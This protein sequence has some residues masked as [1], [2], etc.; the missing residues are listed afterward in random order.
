MPDRRSPA[1]LG[2]FMDNQ[3]HTVT[4][5]RALTCRILAPGLAAMA[6][7]CGSDPVNPAVNTPTAGDTSFSVNFLRAA[8][9]APPIANPI[10]SFYARSG[11]D[12]EAFMY[13]RPRPGGGGSDSTVF[14]RFRVPKDA[15]L[16][17][18]DGSPIAQG[19][20]VLIT[21]TL[22]DPLHLAVDFQP[23]G[24]RFSPSDP[25]KLKLSFLETDEDLN[26]DGVVNIDDL[27]VQNLLALWKRETSASPW[28]RLASVVSTGSH[29][30]EATVTGFTSY[31]IAW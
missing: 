13:Y 19:D 9:S 20:S 18:P 1:P 12:R 8:A 21:I 29:E 22:V 17:R 26:D 30:V 27:A 15:L 2:T 25:A 23:S 4:R 24:L 3:D 31:I 28:T 16:T 10:V 11:V 7:A 14:V 6:V 5:L